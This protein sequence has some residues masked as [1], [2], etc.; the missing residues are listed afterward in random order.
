VRRIATVILQ[1]FLVMLDLVLDP[2]SGKVERRH[3]VRVAIRRHELMFVFGVCQN[4][5]S[6]FVVPITVEVYRYRDLRESVEEMKQLFSLFLKLLL[7]FF[8]Q[9]PMSGRDCHL[10]L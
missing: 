9:V 5:D 3:H 4:F 8:A 10:H 7:V 6:E 1:L 2:F